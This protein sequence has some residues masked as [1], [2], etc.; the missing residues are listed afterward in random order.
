MK[1]LIVSMLLGISLITAVSTTTTTVNA[2]ETS[3]TKT[4]LVRADKYGNNK[5]YRIYEIK[6]GKMVPAQKAFATVGTKRINHWWAQKV[7]IDGKTWWKIGK[8]DYF[9]PTR[10]SVVNTEMMAALGQKIVNYVN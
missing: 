10:V 2:Q 3:E 1:K 4:I 6:K 8:N 7:K 9:K 5:S